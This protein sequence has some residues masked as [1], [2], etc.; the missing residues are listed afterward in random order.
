MIAEKLESNGYNV[1]LQYFDV[2]RITK[3][4][5]YCHMNTIQV[6]VYSN[7]AEGEAQFTA[8]IPALEFTWIF[9][10]V[11]N[12]QLT[13]YRVGKEKC[14]GSRVCSNEIFRQWYCGW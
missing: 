4:V 2:S 14:L 8:S 1:T 7:L 13:E 10:E 3:L 5:L 6:P 11:S 12:K 9:L